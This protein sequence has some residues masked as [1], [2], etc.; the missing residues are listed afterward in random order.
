[1][2]KFFGYYILIVN[3][4]G[5][6]ICGLDKS[7]AKRHAWRIPEKGIFSAALLGGG[8]GVWAGMYL[9][10]HKTR[11]WYFVIGIP[12]IAFVEYGLLAWWMLR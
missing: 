8:F 12:L 7:K 1:M 10:R 2:D 11:H 9:F 3:L 4:A 5:L 6:F